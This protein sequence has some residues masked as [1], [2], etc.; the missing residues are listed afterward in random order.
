M[1]P[2]DPMPNSEVK[3]RNADGSV[4]IPHVRVGHRQVTNRRDPKR[5]L[6][7]FLYLINYQITREIK[8]SLVFINGKN[9]YNFS[10]LFFIP[11]L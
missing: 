8:D 9:I 11:L 3:R 4:G 10:L 1:V 2:P 7:V 6:R 5:M